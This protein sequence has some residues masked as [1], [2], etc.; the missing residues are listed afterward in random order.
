EEDTAEVIIRSKVWYSD[1]S[2]VLQAEMTQFRV[3]NS[4]LA[5]SSTVFKDMFEVGHAPG[6]DDSKVDGQ[7]L[8]HLYDDNANDVELVLMALYD[9]RFFQTSQKSFDLVAAMWRLGK[10]YGFEELRDEALQRLEDFFRARSGPPPPLP[11]YEISIPV[12]P[13]PG[14]HVHAISLARET[15]LVSILPAA[16][17]ACNNKHYQRDIHEVVMAGVLMNG[18]SRAHLSNADKTLCVLAT[19]I[20]IQRQRKAYPAHR[21]LNRTQGCLSTCRAAVERTRDSLM[22]SL[23][24]DPLGPMYMSG[25]CTLCQTA[26]STV[27]NEEQA[28]IWNDLPGIYGLPS[29][30]AIKQEMARYAL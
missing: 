6:D 20:L 16:F 13:C 11:R 27:F 3:H 19:S 10:K 29:W 2:V 30:G 26:A 7:P 24:V 17:Y 18:G 23:R 5:A 14:I 9:R 1:G 28:K 21:A 4:I 8:V 22:D 15:G 12:P 25:A